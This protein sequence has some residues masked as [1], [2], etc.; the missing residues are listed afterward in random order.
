[1]SP[2]CLTLAMLGSYR[3]RLQQPGSCSAEP[4][5]TP[6]LARHMQ[7]HRLG[8]EAGCAEDLYPLVLAAG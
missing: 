6:C 3:G 4:V 5:T 1:M 8:L 7:Q 2:C